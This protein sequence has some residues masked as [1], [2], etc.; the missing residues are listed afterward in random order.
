MGRS[1]AAPGSQTVSRPRRARTT[2]PPSPR[3]RRGARLDPASRPSGGQ[4]LLG[5][6]VGE[7]PV[8]CLMVEDERQLAGRVVVGA[9]RGENQAASRV[10]APSGGGG[11]A[12]GERNVEAGVEATGT[13]LG[14][15]PSRLGRSR[16]RRAARFRPPPLAPERAGLGARAPRHPASA[17]LGVLSAPRTRRPPPRRREHP[18]AGHEPACCASRAGP[19]PRASGA[20]HPGAAGSATRGA[21]ARR[22][23]LASTL[24]VCSA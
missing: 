13:D 6:R 14:S 17:A 21:G 4:H 3:R 8:R 2:R 11:E 18:H 22:N 15:D 10:S 1:E 16:R 12:A 24:V 9:S 20:C 7:Q 19:R 23:H 5:A